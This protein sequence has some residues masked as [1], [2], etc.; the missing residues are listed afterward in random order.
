MRFPIY[1]IGVVVVLGVMGC[2]ERQ[3]HIAAAIHP[4]DSVSTMTSYG[5]NTLISDSGIIKYRIIAER[6]DVNQAKKVSRWTFDKGLFLEQFDQ[7]LHINSYI[8]SDTAYYYDQKRIWELR[9]RVRVLTK[10]GLRYTG[11]EL[12]WDENKHEL[13]SNVYS[14]LVTP[15]RTLEGTYFRS[16]ERMTKYYVSNSKGSFERSDIEDESSDSIRTA[17]DSVKNSVR[18]QAPPRR[19]KNLSVAP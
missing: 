10:D 13:W 4:R 12:F 16:D 8:Q 6:W 18:Q 2:E 5:V 7:K 14:H 19:S 9:G 3:E 11:E 15:E 1:I 17:P